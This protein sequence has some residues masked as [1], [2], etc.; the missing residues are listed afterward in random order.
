MELAAAHIDPHVAAAGH[1]DGVAR[2]AKR[3]GIESDGGVLAGNLQ[4]DVPDLD[5]A[6]KSVACAAW[7]TEGGD[8]HGGGYK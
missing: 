8:A 5:D 4:V 3:T 1:G 7:C 2:Q 6:S